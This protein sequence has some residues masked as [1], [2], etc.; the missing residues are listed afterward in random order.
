MLS[1]RAHARD[2]TVGAKNTPA[3]WRDQS[4][5][6]KPLASFGIRIAGS[7]FSFL[8]KHF[9][10]IPRFVQRRSL[11]A[12]RLHTLVMSSE[13]ETSLDISEIVR[14]SSASVGMTEL[15]LLLEHFDCIPSLIGRRLFEFQRARQIHLSKSILRIKFEKV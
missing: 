4:P 3:T 6:E 7:R 13:V 8:L 5:N 10:R 14:D 15:L 1:S 11:V 2:L 12:I 9:D